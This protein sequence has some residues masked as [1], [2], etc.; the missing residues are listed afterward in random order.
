MV[1]TEQNPLKLGMSLLGLGLLILVMT[2]HLSASD[3]TVSGVIL[4]GMI[5]G[6]AVLL[7]AI[8]FPVMASFPKWKQYAQRRQTAIQGQSAFPLATSQPTLPETSLHLP[9][10]ITSARRKLLFAA[11]VILIGAGCFLILTGKRGN[12]DRLASGDWFIW[13]L[14]LITIMGFLYPCGS[15]LLALFKAERILVTTETLEVG[16]SAF[17]ESSIRGKHPSMRWDDARLFVVHRG[18][19]FWRASPRYELIGTSTSIQWHDYRQSRWWTLQRAD[20]RYAEQMEM[21]L[22]YISA[23]TGLP[24]YDLR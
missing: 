12:L 2:F 19:K 11:Y 15:L 24:L 13:L 14:S 4:D 1:V 9:L 17:D 16:N 10:R 21:L 6:L 20:E 3:Q 7:I 22:A 23:R 8:S 5:H 18:D